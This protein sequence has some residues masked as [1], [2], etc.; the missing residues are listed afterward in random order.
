MQA[1]QQIFCD[2]LKC[3]NYTLIERNRPDE[4]YPTLDESVAENR[5]GSPEGVPVPGSSLQM[6][7]IV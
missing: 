3:E 7:W 4:S 6:Y 1:P 5:G 2:D